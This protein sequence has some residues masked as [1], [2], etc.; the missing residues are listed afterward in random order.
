[1]TKDNPSCFISYNRKDIDKDTLE[2]LISWIKKLSPNTLTVHYDE[3]LSF[4]DDIYKFIKL[5]EEVD[6][7]I[8]ILSPGYKEKIINRTPGGVYEEYKIIEKRYLKLEENRKSDPMFKERQFIV[9]PILFSGTPETATLEDDW[10]RHKKFLDIT[11]LRVHKRKKNKKEE[12]FLNKSL[13][14]KYK[15]DIKELVNNMTTINSINSPSYKKSLKRLFNY[16]FKVTKAEWEDSMGEGLD[17]IKEYVFVKTFSYNKISE[18]EAHILVGR[19][20]SGKSTAAIFLSHKT[21]SQYFGNIPLIADDFDLNKIFSIFELQQ[22][23][24]EAKDWISRYKIFR[25]AW[26]LLIN[27]ACLLLLVHNKPENLVIDNLKNYASELYNT[28]AEEEEEEDL[29]SLFDYCLVSVIRYWNHCIREA[30]SDEKYFIPDIT[31]NFTLPKLIKYVFGNKVLA[32]FNQILEENNFTFLLTIDGFDTEYDKYRM[33]ILSIAS[34]DIVEE[35]TQIELDWISALLHVATYMKRMRTRKTEKINKLMDFCLSIPKDRFTEIQLMERDS[36]IY[37]HKYV[38]INWSGI[39]LAIL[40]R[41]R[42]EMLRSYPT[43]KSLSVEDRLDEVLSKEY[44]SIPSKIRTT[45]GGKTYIVPTFLYILRHTFWR[46]RDLLYFYAK[47]IA[48][49][50]DVRKKKM[51]LN[52]DM[53]RRLVKLSTEQIIQQEFIGEF[54][55]SLVNIEKIM[56]VFKESNQIISYGELT[57]KLSKV[58]FHFA[59]TQEAVKDIRDKFNYLYDIGFI[60]IKATKQMMKTY[61]LGNK[62]VFNFNEGIGPLRAFGTTLF[63]SSEFVIHP[64]FCEYLH[65]DTSTNELILEFTWDYLHEIEALRWHE[66]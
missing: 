25:Y 55:S 64:I 43:D 15:N 12:V 1:M 21:K 28:T 29:A 34:Q 26:T 56:D 54:K 44:S 52:D 8:I 46:P 35:K 11:Q 30:R 22:V 57:K 4:G 23:R 45:V 58:D 3:N 65:L 48:L 20:G 16:L 49:S 5:L 40:L 24:S 9:L 53:V 59:F 39:E 61:A 33:N 27:H 17:A 41:K 31:R 51:E 10:I 42:L 13:V 47:L 14:K 38:E 18:Q 36:Y 63:K 32:E 50:D 6:A 62:H 66:E 2:Y 60:G 19:K 37:R 7:V